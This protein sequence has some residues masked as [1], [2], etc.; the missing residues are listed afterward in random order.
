MTSP[1]EI[2]HID[3]VG[4]TKTKGLKGD[5]YFMVLV[6]DYTRITP[7]L[8]LKKSHKL[9]K[10]SRSTRKWLKMKWIQKSNA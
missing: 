4:P 7:V 6:D 10:T 1:L 3:L 2:V 9:L 8:F 5:K